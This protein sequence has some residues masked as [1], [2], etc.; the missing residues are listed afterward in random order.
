[1]TGEL[2]F[3]LRPCPWRKNSFVV[4]VVLTFCLQPT[5]YG[6][7][8]SPPPPQPGIE[9]TPPALEGRVLTSRP[10]G[11]PHCCC[12][13]FNYGRGLSKF[14]CGGRSRRCRRSVESQVG[15][16]GIR[17]IQ[18]SSKELTVCPLLAGECVLGIFPARLEAASFPAHRAPP[19]ACQS[20]YGLSSFP[21][22]LECVFQDLFYLFLAARGLHCCTRACSSCG[23]E[24]VLLGLIAE[25]SLVVEHRL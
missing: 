4:V 12:F 14:V 6:I 15:R 5:A 21:L 13:A 7:L 25:V 23:E 10:P 22:S 2:E 17:A 19:P 24:V 16:E 3:Y 8:V 9:P 11:N 18:S 1:M 20:P